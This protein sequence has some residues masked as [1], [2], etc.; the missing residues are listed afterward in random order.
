M[1]MVLSTNELQR[2]Q[3]E[4]AAIAQQHVGEQQ[5]E[6]NT[7]KKRDSKRLLIKIVCRS[8]S[9]SVASKSWPSMEPKQRAQQAMRRL[10]II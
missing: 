4:C 3:I 7:E 9:N 1:T 6:I 2:F 5:R 8:K 10:N